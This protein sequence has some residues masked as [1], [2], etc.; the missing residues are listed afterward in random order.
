MGI[1][2]HAGL[3]PANLQQMVHISRGAGSNTGG[4]VPREGVYLQEST[5][6]VVGEVQ[7]PQVVQPVAGQVLQGGS[8]VLEI[9]PQQQQGQQ[10]A[11]PLRQPHQEEAQQQAAQV[12]VQ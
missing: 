8:Y 1:L 7:Q 11:V 5:P 2:S 10:V 4:P 6:V 12:W 9:V 3:L